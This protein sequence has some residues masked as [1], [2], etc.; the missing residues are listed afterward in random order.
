MINH[1]SDK[2]E[3]FE[4]QDS[5]RKDIKHPEN[6]DEAVVKPEDLDYEQ[7]EGDF[8][9]VADYKEKREQPVLPVKDAPKDV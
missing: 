9:N 6:D 8:G 7:Q 1:Q 2:P 5:R 4:P 3:K